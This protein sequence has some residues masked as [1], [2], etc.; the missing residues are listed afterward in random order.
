MRRHLSLRWKLII[1][2]VIVE[3]V[4][5][6]VLVFN[7]V[8]LIETSLAEQVDL[9]LKEVS[10]L[11]NAA[12]GPNLA[13]QDYG[14]ILD[15]FAASRREQGIVY[16]ALWDNRG[17]LVAMDGWP[18]S[19]AMP[20]P[21][22]RLDVRSETGR[23]DTRMPITVGNQTYGQLQF[24]ISTR[25]LVEAR[26]N[27]THQSLAIAGVEVV[28]SIA[29]L[30]L[31][32]IWLTRHLKTLEEASRAVS[33][34]NYDLRLKVNSKDEIGSLSRAFNTMATEISTRMDALRV[35]EERFRHLSE[36]ASDWYWEQ[37]AEFRFTAFAGASFRDYPQ[38][39]TTL[40]G[41]RRWDSK[42]IHI[43]PQ[44]MAAHRAV[45]EAHQAFRDL[46]YKTISDSGK[47]SWLTIS[48]TPIF[49]SDG[50]FSGY[51]GSGRDITE[52]KLAEFAMLESE[53][54]FASLFQLSPLPMALTDLETGLISDVNESWTKLFGYSHSEAVARSLELL[55][56]FTHEQQRLA[57]EDLIVRYGNCESIEAQLSAHDGSTL[58][59]EL[60]GRTLEIGER[61]FFLWC[62]RD[63]TQQRRA[64]A[65]IRDLNARLEIR[66]AERTRELENTLETLNRAQ[67]N[68]INSEKLAA[69]GRVVAAV[70]HELNTPIGNSVMVA[71]TLEEKAR[72]FAALVESG[73][74]R[75]S[76]INDYVQGSCA[77][78]EMLVRNL[79]QAHNLIYSFKQVAVD[80]TSDRRREFELKTMAAEIAATM[81]PTLR[82]T[83]YQLELDIEDGLLM[84]SYPG[85]LGQVITNF[86]NNALLHA[87]DGMSGGKMTLV[88]RGKPDTGFIQLSFSDDGR[89]MDAEHLKHIFDPFFTTRLGQGGSG[90]GLNIVYNLVT[91]ILGGSIEVTSTPWKGTSFLLYLPKVAPEREAQ[92]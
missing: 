11:L 12:L 26:R 91:R 13:A 53:Q 74:I 90:L 86:V 43:S 58:S 71:T 57:F 45:C 20:T 79:Q 14:P 63:I 49:D 69:L 85:P 6:T 82:K 1:G 3:V 33:A 39:A 72:E 18:S 68:L 7:S 29:L 64:E 15:V 54:K 92:E 8:R 87:F 2:S 37:D 83:P 59:G 77:G 52:R 73:S 41:Q 5:L 89:G 75:R 16:F 4:M 23:F 31:I 46:E 17:R 50:N 55:H 78:T 61:R 19:Q 40:V 30:I 66:V 65:Q 42:L 56:L 44:E 36:L 51:R 9:R 70:A 62:V 76:Q 67:D 47:V 32:G 25:F 84:N 27:L 80:Q 22:A 35:S 21:A 81:A 60:A 24:G 38:L 48:G 10:V 28:L 88:A 34:G